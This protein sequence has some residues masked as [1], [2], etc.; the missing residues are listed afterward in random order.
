MQ[1]SRRAFLLGRRPV[2]SPWAAFMERLTLLCQG[3][4][5]DL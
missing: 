4:V 1:P 5:R 2:R 3:A